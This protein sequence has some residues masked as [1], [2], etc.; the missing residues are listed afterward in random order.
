M[1]K[2]T[3]EEVWDEISK[4]WSEFRNEP[5]R[6][7]VD[8]LAGKSGKILDLA[9]GSGRHFI[10]LKGTIF[11]VDFSSRML[12]YAKDYASKK[13]INVVLKQANAYALPFEDDFFDCALYIAGLHCIDSEE[14]REKSLKELFRVLKPASR[15]LLSVWSRNNK[16]VKNKLG[17][18]TVPWTVGEK[19][20]ERYY[21]IY[22][23]EELKKLLEK[24]GFKILSMKEDENIW[25][26]IEKP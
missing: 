2:L 9:C 23:Q 12:K 18:I 14:N 6:E 3:Q 7:V 26:V 25:A 24:L 4:S 19:K 13:K 5:Q 17:E 22:E 11:G 8:F 15:A 10:K 1:V 16:R 20:Y 21:Y